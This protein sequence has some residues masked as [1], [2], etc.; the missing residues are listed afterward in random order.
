VESGFTSHICC[1]IVSELFSF[2]EVSTAKC[3]H[4]KQI[5]FVDPNSVFSISTIHS[6]E[7][8]LAVCCTLDKSWPRVTLRVLGT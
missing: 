7:C 2:S 3:F 5:P 1:V 6:I 4:S 8:S